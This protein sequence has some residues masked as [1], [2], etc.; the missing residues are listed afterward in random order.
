MEYLFVSPAEQKFE[1][2]ERGGKC[3]FSKLKF[4]YVPGVAFSVL[5]SFIQSSNFSPRDSIHNTPMTI[6]YDSAK[7][8][9]IGTVLL[10][11]SVIYFDL[12]TGY[13][14]MYGKGERQF[15]EI[16][17]KSN[18]GQMTTYLN[19]E[20]TLSGVTLQNIAVLPSTKE[21]WKIIY[22]DVTD[23]ISK[24]CGTATQ[25]LV[26]LG[27]SGVINDKS[28]DANFSFEYIKLITMNAPY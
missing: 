10:K 27:I 2:L 15:W 7:G 12:V 21:E 24:A 6:V 23:V 19:F 13:N 4:E 3:N 5:E 1:N 14:P 26:R 17:Y 20:K 16:S 8:R 9:N 18:N 22:I 11:D 28:Q 25:V